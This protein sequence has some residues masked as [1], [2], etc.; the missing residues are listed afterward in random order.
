M[1]ACVSV[2][3]C[4]SA[5][6]ICVSVFVYVMYMC[7]YIHNTHSHIC[8]NTLIHPG[9]LIFMLLHFHVEMHFSR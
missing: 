9:I 7:V 4:V 3:V 8:T 6:H 5:C 1:C 2:Y